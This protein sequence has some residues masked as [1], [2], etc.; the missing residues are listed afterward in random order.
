MRIPPLVKQLLRRTG[1]LFAIF[2][3]AVIV[4][5]FI[6]W[7]PKFAERIH[8]LCMWIAAISLF[9]QVA[10]W[11]NVLVTYG[12]GRYIERHATDPGTAMTVRTV[13][14]LVKLAIWGIIAVNIAWIFFH[15]SL[16]GLVA[17]LGVGGIAIA[18]ALQSILTDIFA[19]LSIITDKPFLIGD[20]IQVD[21]FSGTVEH[22]GLKSTRVRAYT[23]EQIVF[24]NGDITKARLRNFSR[25]DM[26]Q[27]T[28]TTRVA[29]SATP[30]QLQRVP[31]ILKDV[32]DARPAI[33]FVRAT[34]TGVGDAWYEYTTLYN[35]DTA[36]YQLYADTQQAI[37]IEALRRFEQEHIETA[38]E[39]ESAQKLKIAG[40]D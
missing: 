18:F 11:A 32:V 1:V 22:I 33:K 13:S 21:N 3:I 29:A 39:L 10:I 28:V 27:G 4:P 16:T 37:V 38:P 2:L 6:D 15:V 34:L 20:A 36:D 9:F 14:I 8:E 17:G 35:L 40:I 30:D 31:K 19:S 26:R 24:S 25:M 12:S 23:G 7:P 5:P